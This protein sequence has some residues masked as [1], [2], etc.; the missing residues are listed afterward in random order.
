MFSLAVVLPPSAAGSSAV[1]AMT[2]PRT[3]LMGP[4][5]EP[6]VDDS[7]LTG[8]GLRLNQTTLSELWY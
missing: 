4:S 3:F 8:D 5:S 1:A 6:H 2:R 7:H